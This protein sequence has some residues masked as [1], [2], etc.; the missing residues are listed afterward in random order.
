MAAQKPDNVYTKLE[1]L[2]VH[3]CNIIVKICRV[4]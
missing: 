1:Q 2:L 3:E 4:L